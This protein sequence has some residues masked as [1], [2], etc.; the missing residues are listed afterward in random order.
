MQNFRRYPNKPRSKTID[1]IVSSRRQSSGSIDFRR[2]QT[3]QLKPRAV[4]IDNFSRPQGFRPGQRAQIA[5]PGMGTAANLHGVRSRPGAHSTASATKHDRKKKRTPRQLLMRSMMSVALV[6]LIGGGF[7]FGKGYLKARQIFKGGADGA[8]ALQDNVDPSLL[9]GEGDGRVNIML[10]G[11]GGEGH[12]AADLTDTLLI[13][14]IDPLQKESALVSVPRDFYVR[15]PDLGSMKINSVYANAKQQA[16]NGSQSPNQ[17]KEADKA[18]LQAVKQAL[19]ESMG[20]PIHYYAMVDFEA[21]R[22]AID[23]VGGITI[24]VPEQLYDP[25]VA[26]ENNNN[27]LIASQGVQHFNGKRALLY[28]RS[29]HGSARGDFDR[30]ARQRA[31]IV[32]L[33][34]KVL[35]AGTF[36]NPLKISQLADAFGDH[37]HTDLNVNDLMRLYTIAKEM[38]SDKVASIGLADPPNNFITTDFV[39]GQSVV[40]PTAGVFNFKEIQSYIRNTLKD[41]F[42][43]NENASVTIL[44]GTT[45]TG[46]ATG[47]SEELKS[48]GY[49]VDTIGDTPTK[50][51]SHTILVD[52]RKGDK[53]Y[54]RRYLEKRL[55]VTAIDNLP[56]GAI[57]P[58]N[59]DFVII[60]GRN[61]S[62]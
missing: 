49:N 27:P 29:R 14:S 1:G 7:L 55:N 28:A 18:G 3:P 34:D 32:A 13:A 23:T 37:V 8:A 39:D 53:K 48:Y 56:D 58:G 46:L 2:P 51:Y 10:L 54:T 26:W 22:K 38:P 61:E 33:K 24:D 11:R 52:L 16:L 59:A 62:L 30:A 17:I 40:V 15:V 47:R 5:A 43:R 25:M 60:L 35:S 6:G 42:L 20:I 44:N 57:Q 41:G 19:E 50:N 12:T 9:R 45:T 4:T 21:F 36:G 31:I